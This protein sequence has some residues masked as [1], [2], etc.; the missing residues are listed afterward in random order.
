MKRWID[1]YKTKNKSDQQLITQTSHPSSTKCRRNSSI[2]F[3]NT[4][5]NQAQISNY[6]LIL[7]TI[8]KEYI[9]NYVYAHADAAR[10]S[11]WVEYSWYEKRVLALFTRETATAVHTLH[12]RGSREEYHCWTHVR[13]IMLRNPWISVTGTNAVLYVLFKRYAGVMLVC[14]SEY[15]ILVEKSFEI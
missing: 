9:M 13:T 10:R 8:G 3:E 15:F 12:P 4:D 14:Q 2:S 7:C 11:I 5:D 1:R 6:A